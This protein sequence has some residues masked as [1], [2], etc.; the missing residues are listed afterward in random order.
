MIEVDNV[1]KAREIL[2]RHGIETGTTNLPNLS[3][4]TNINLQNAPL[5]KLKRL[6]VPLHSRLTLKD[7]ESLFV[8]LKKHSLISP[9]S[10]IKP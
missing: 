9:T 2:F 8:L 1:S 10:E 7:Y 3:M 6:F 5:L 4:G